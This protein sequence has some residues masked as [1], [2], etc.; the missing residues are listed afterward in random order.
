MYGKFLENL[1]HSWKFFFNFESYEYLGDIS[2]KMNQVLHNVFRN[3]LPKNRKQKISRYK[4]GNK[5]MFM[6]RSSNE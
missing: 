3:I 1:R 6:Y 2:R 4:T 5:N